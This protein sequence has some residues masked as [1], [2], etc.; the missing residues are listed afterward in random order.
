M[1]SSGIQD[2]K[3]AHG[4]QKHL[5]AQTHTHKTNI[6]SFNLT[7]AAITSEQHSDKSELILMK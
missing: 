6:Q 1:P 5:Q 3:Q 7:P 4:A 2:I